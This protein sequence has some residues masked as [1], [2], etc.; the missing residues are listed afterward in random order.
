MWV[1]HIENK[2]GH[3]E[4]YSYQQ[5]LK[6]EKIKQNTIFNLA[7][8]GSWPG[9]SPR[10]NSKECSGRRKMFS[11]ELSEHRSGNWDSPDLLVFSIFLFPT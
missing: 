10:G 6:N 9:D 5:S 3:L 11:S 4:F 7:E 8:A 2:C 1:K